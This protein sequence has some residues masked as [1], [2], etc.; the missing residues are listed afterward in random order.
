MNRFIPCVD[1][2]EPPTIFQVKVH[3][4][5]TIIK[6]RVDESKQL[7]SRGKGVALEDMERFG[8]DCFVWQCEHKASPM[9]ADNQELFFLFLFLHPPYRA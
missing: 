6:G 8:F 4:F 7:V 9:L 5:G 1:Y 3:W 2:K